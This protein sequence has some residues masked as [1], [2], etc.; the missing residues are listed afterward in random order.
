MMGRVPLILMVV[1]GEDR[2]ILIRLQWIPPMLMRSMLTFGT[3]T[4]YAIM[5]NCYSSIMMGITG[6]Q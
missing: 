4:S 3:E 1:E 6:I 5:V 2:V